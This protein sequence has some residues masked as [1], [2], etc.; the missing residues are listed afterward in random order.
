M[1][2]FGL[3]LAVSSV[4]WPALVGAEDGK[5]RKPSPRSAQSRAQAL[6]SMWW[7]DAALVEDLSLSDAVRTRMNRLYDAY[8]DERPQIG[9]GRAAFRD[10]LDEGDWEK[11]RKRLDEAVVEAGEPLRAQGELKIAIF[12]LLTDEQRA[13]LAKRNP[14]PIRQPWMVGRRAATGQREQPSQPAEE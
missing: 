4:L 1:Q 11:A 13:K 9:A 6:K 12:S 14:N 10:A 8:L 5:A 7:N 2:L 3:A